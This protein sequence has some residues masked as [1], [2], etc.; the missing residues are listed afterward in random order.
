MAELALQPRDRLPH[1]AELALA[2]IV[3]GSDG[4]RS[5][6]FD[7]IILLHVDLMDHVSRWTHFAFVALASF[8]TFFGVED[9][10]Q[11]PVQKSS[12]SGV[13]VVDCRKVRFQ[14][15]LYGLAHPGLPLMLTHVVAVDLGELLLT[16]DH[17]LAP[18]QHEWFDGRLILES[19]G[20]FWNA[21]FLQ[22]I[23][24]HDVFGLL[25]RRLR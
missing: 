15:L 1:Q 7:D 25:L 22:S 23:F 5:W 12:V 11:K 18:R 16:P 2:A 10:G 8:A 17:Q 3:D 9:A 4:T 21:M 13:L 6:S 14:L 20:L 19:W 24:D